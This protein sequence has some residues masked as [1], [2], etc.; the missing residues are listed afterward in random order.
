L[1]LGFQPVR[2]NAQP[3]GFDVEA[4]VPCDR[5]LRHKQQVMANDSLG[6]LF[7]GT[8]H[9]LQVEIPGLGDTSVIDTKHIYAWVSAPCH[10]VLYCINRGC[11]QFAKPARSPP[12]AGWETKL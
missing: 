9:D 7:Q 10:G 8:V 4:T 6:A 2:D 12:L 1:E 11:G 5:W 3:Y